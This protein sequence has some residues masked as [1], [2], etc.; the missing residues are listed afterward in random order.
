MTTTTTIKMGFDTIEI[1]LVL[2]Q[3]GFRIYTNLT[4]LVTIVTYKLTRLI[5]IVSKPISIVVV[6]VVIVVVVFVQKS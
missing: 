5:S 1:N 2:L 3:K 4:C 6:V